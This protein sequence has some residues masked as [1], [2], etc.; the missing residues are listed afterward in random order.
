MTLDNRLRAICDL[1]LPAARENGRHEYDGQVQDLSCAGIRTGLARLGGPSYE[2]PHDD[3]HAGAA[4]E[5]LRARFGEMELHRSSP[6]VHL[7]NL[8]LTSYERQYAPEE[9]RRQAVAEHLG[10]WPEVVDVAVTTLDRV[11]APLA[12]ASMPLARGLAADLDRAD[13]ATRV[14]AER[15]LERLISHLERAAEHGAPSAALGGRVL[16]RMLSTS[17]ACE[18]ELSTLAATVDAERRRLRAELD[19]ACRRIDP[20]AGTEEVV[21]ALRADHPTA[22]NLLADTRKLVD[23]AL[24]WTERTGLAPYHDGEC[25]VGHTPLAQRRAAAGLFG[26]APAEMDSPS[27]F[28]VTPPDEDWTDREKDEWLGSYFNRANLANIVIH[29]V[30]PGHFSHFR[31]LRRVSSPVRRTL[32]SDV[33]QEGWAHYIEQV[34]LEEGFHAHDPAYPVGVHLDAL[35]RVARLAAAIGLHTGAMTIEDAA[36]QFREDAFLSGQSALAEARRGLF[37]P[38]YGRY[39][40]GKL[41]ILDARERARTAWGK[42]FSLPRFHTA[43]LALGAPP[44]GLLDTAIERG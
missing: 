9:D 10:R 1:S 31:A 14:A 17:E 7:D 21:R 30:A 6:L 27:W 39:T 24:D 44:I 37:D 18:V 29:E 4:E 41:A 16:A 38:T 19:E 40:W 12:R 3:T 2:D 25:L 32:I 13:G 23:E 15:A 34:A 11:P 43:L 33:F 28:Y 42:G 5:S 36:H 20:K 8:D 26:S 22:E 35:R